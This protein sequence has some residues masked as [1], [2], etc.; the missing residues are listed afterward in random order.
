[1]DIANVDCEVQYMAAPTL[2]VHVQRLGR[3]G[4][5]GQPAL[6]ILL[7]E[8]SI[9]QTVKKNKLKKNQKD[10]VAVKAEDLDDDMADGEGDIDD[11]EINHRKKLEHGMRQWAQTLTCRRGVSNK[12]F[13]NPP[14]LK[15]HVP[16]NL[17]QNSI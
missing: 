16:F 15:G 3:T 11:I 6:S 14:N 1:M 7:A 17:K 9:F 12:Y 2:S 4:R 8:P 5:S 10:D 13:N